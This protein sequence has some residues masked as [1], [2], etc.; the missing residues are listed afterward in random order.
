MDKREAILEAARE[1][2]AERGFYGTPVVISK[3]TLFN[4]GL[5]HS[6]TLCV[7]GHCNYGEV[8]VSDNQANLFGADGLCGVVGA[9]DTS[10]GAVKNM[11]R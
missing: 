4:N 11:Y 3:I 7:E 1:L 8:V 5:G 10:W 2:F 9:D 6:M